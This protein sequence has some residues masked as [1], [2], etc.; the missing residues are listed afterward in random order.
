MYAYKKACT[1]ILPNFQSSL[2]YV[3]CVNLRV[4]HKY[5]RIH[6]HTHIHTLTCRQTQAFHIHMH[7]LTCT[8]TIHAHTHPHI[9]KAFGEGRSDNG[10]AIPFNDLA[11]PFNDRT[12]GGGGGG[13]G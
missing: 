4:T 10:L 13:D 12:G 8:R 9:G 5:T 3:H 6:L 2:L 1:C 7:T 11:I